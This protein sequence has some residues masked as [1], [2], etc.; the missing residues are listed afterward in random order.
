M[1]V[2]MSSSLALALATSK[3]RARLSLH[4]ECLPP[5]RSPKSSS[6]GWSESPRKN[7]TPKQGQYLALIYA[8]ARLHRGPPGEADMQQH[9]RVSPPSVHHMVLTF[10][11]AGLIRRQPGAARA[12]KCSLI[13][14]A[15][16]FYVDPRQTGQN[17]CVE[18]L[19]PISAVL[20]RD[21]LGCSGERIWPQCAL[22]A[23]F[24][25]QE[26]ANYY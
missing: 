24:S 6:D 5:R 10:E 7:F 16:Q 14:N 1:L 15:S 8:Y 11:R 18:I 23:A 22:M 19:E 20:N 17:H 25:T 12:S 21:S 26:Y 2:M 4:A 9:F 13:P 3:I